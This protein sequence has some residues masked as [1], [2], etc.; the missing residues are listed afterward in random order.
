MLKPDV[1]EGEAVLA[2]PAAFRRLC[3]ETLKD[4]L[5]YGYE[6]ASRLQAAVC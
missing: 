3:V 4:G 5:E 6:L 1:Q 2:R